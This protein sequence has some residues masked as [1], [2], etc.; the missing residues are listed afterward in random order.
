MAGFSND[1]VLAIMIVVAAL[2]AGSEPTR[3]AGCGH[4]K[5]VEG[6]SAHC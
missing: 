2:K 3:R 6:L 4:V 5:N 1:K